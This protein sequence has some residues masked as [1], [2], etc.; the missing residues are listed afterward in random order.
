MQQDQHG[1][2]QGIFGMNENIEKL[3]I[4][5][6]SSGAAK[7]LKKRKRIG[8]LSLK[9]IRTYNRMVEGLKKKSEKKAPIIL[10]EYRGKEALARTLDIL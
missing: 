8:K 1:E 9:H 6:R 7:Y 10:P 4:L 3:I 2:R 5:R